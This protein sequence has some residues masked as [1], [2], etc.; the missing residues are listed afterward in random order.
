MAQQ[1]SSCR[2]RLQPDYRSDCV[3]VVK[4]ARLNG[5][6]V[7]SE[8]KGNSLKVSGEGLHA[9]TSPAAAATVVLR[10]ELA[11]KSSLTRVTFRL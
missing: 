5:E 3:P 11:L 7:A 6:N 1:L 4:V 8:K 10:Q 2:E 9:V